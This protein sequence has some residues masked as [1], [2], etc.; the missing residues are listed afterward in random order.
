MTLI[1]RTV[2]AAEAGVEKT[3]GM[4]VG[5]GFAYTHWA[6]DKTPILQLPNNPFP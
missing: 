6:L 2:L 1:L 5:P 3:L 4:K